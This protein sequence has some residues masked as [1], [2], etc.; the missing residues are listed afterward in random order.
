MTTL[1]YNI[2]PCPRDDGTLIGEPQERSDGRIVVLHEDI[3]A[4]G[5]E[6]HAG[7]YY[8][9]LYTDTELQ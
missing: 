2:C 7:S 4:A 1:S 6:V 8:G 3:L 5:L 9:A